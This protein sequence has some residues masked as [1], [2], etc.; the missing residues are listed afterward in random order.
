MKERNCLGGSHLCLR[1][2]GRTMVE[3]HGLAHATS[4][5]AKECCREG[6]HDNE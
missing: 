2:Q 5:R 3:R 4:G 1:G 6:R